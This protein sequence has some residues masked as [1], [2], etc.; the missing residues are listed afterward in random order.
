MPEM[1]QENG[2]LLI[3]ALVVAA[4]ILLWFL[5]S[6]R[7]TKIQKDGS[8]GDS[9]GVAKR[10]Q[11]LI[12]A[13]PATLK[14]AEIEPAS[15]AKAAPIPTPSASNADD[16]SRIKGVGPKLKTMLLDMGI[17]SFAEIAAWTDADI[18]R[19]DSGLGRFE[20]R[21]RRDNWPE[22][23]RLLSGDDTAAY[24]AEFGRL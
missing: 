4:L 1:M 13:A 9:D 14:Q 20:G 8:A 17:T 6:S 11:S 2:T 5:L 23:A 10:N 18:D 24:E 3:T 12:D 7:K 22:Q 21:I 16:L 19:V 15:E